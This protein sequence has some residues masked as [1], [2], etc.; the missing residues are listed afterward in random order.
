MSSSRSPQ[1]P[2]SARVDSADCALNRAL[3]D[4]VQRAKRD[5]TQLPGAVR[6]ADE[7]MA[8]MRLNGFGAAHAINAFKMRGDLDGCLR[9]LSYLDRAGIA[10]TQYHYSLAIAASAR[11]RVWLKAI[12]LLK[13][14]ESKDIVPDTFT[15]SSAITACEKGGRWEEALGL[16]SEMASKGVERDTITFNAAISACGKGGQWEEALG[17]LREMASEGVERDT[18]TYSAAISAC[19]KG[20]RWA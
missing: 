16:L 17:L 5:Q 4:A 12:D 18:V 6:S 14:K 20:G 13:E 1:V 19:G 11:N 9:A 15:F 2:G 3:R 8:S 7:L 10:A